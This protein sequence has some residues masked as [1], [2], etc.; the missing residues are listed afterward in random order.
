MVTVGPG[1]SKPMTRMRHVPLVTSEAGTKTFSTGLMLSRSA[2]SVKAP[3][4][5]RWIAWFEAGCV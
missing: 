5:K 1:T 4:A 2:K 3:A